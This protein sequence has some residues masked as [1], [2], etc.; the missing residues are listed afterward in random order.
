MPTNTT[1]REMLELIYGPALD[2]D[3]AAWQNAGESWTRISDLIHERC[4]VRV[5]RPSLVSWYSQRSAA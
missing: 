3:I 1:K 5:S 4:G 2:A